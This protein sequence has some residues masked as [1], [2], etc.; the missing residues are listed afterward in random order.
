LIGNNPNDLKQDLQNR[1]S[2]AILVQ[3]AENLKKTLESVQKCIEDPQHKLTIT[4][5]IQGSPFQ[6]RVWEA[7]CDIPKGTVASYTDIAIK[8]GLPNAI[9][10]VA[11]ACAA[12][13]L[14]IV[15]PCHRV[16]RSDGKISGYRWGVKIKRQLL[17]K[18]GVVAFCENKIQ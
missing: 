8:I 18:E 13:P 5:D 17:Q 14:A 11:G 15:I 7:L 4:L 16:I 3:D 6:K 9:R 10:A 12:N 1:F 2:Y